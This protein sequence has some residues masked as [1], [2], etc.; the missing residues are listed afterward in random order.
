MARKQTT[1]TGTQRDYTVTGQFTVRIV[2]GNKVVWSKTVERSTKHPAHKTR[3]DM[4]PEIDA[5]AEMRQ[6]LIRLGCSPVRAKT[7]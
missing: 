5:I 4:Q 6:E 3:A 2:N 7:F 1:W